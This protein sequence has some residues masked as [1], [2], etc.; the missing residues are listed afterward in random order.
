MLGQ[1]HHNLARAVHQL[2]V[3]REHHRLR[4]HRRVD[5]HARQ[6]RR[7]HRLGP[8]GDRK[9]LL[10]QR[11]QLLLAHALAPARQRRAVEHQPVLEELLAA[12]ELEIRVLHP[13]IAHASSERSYIYLR[14]AKPAISRVGSGGLPGPSV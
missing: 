7:L 3:G 10:Q 8:C 12:E 13:A 2:G 4:L 1:P 9:A 5:D 6:V 14:I 11:L